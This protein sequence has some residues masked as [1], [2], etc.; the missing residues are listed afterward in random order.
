MSRQRKEWT[1]YDETTDKWVEPHL[2]RDDL[3][4]LYREGKINDY[5]EVVNVRTARPQGPGM[6]VHGVLYSQLSNVDV[7]TRSRRHSFVA[8]A[9]T[10]AGPLAQGLAVQAEGRPFG[11]P[12]RKTALSRGTH[13]PLHSR[14]RVS[15]GSGR[16]AR[17]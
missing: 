16:C 14:L 13:S 1:Y 7:S 4:S 5:T 8:G 17:C 10:Y 2:R 3:T 9:D 11:G 15:S 6:G 12:R